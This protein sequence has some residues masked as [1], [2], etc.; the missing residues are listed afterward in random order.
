MRSI[1]YPQC[2]KSDSLYRAGYNQLIA[3]IFLLDVR[4]RYHY[5]Y[6]AANDKKVAITIDDG[7]NNPA[8]DQLLST[9]KLYNVP[10]TLFYIGERALARP[11]LVKKAS[12]LGFDVEDHTFTHAYSVQSSYG[13]LSFE[14]Q[15]TGYLLNQITG[16]KPYFYRPPYLLG[17]GIDPTINPYIKPSQDLLWALELGY[18]PVGSDIDPKDWLATSS[19]EIV[20]GLEKAIHESNNGHIILLHED[21]VTAR[22]IG[23]VVAYLRD[24]GYTI[25]PLKELLTPPTTFALAGTMKAGDTDHTTA[26][27]V[28]KL[29]WFLYK[30][31]YLD[32]YALTGVFDEQTKDA[33][34]SF[35]VD[36]KLVDS[37]DPNLQI[38][39]IA[40]PATRA[41]IQK[42][43]E[44]AAVKNAGT[45]LVYTPTVF[46]RIAGF[47][48][49]MLRGFY[50]T[51]F[52]VFFSFL[53]TMI[54]LT[55]L[56]V[57]GRSLGLVALLIWGK[58]RNVV[59]PPISTTGSEGVSILIPAYNEQENIAATVESVIRTSYPTREI[60]VIDDGSKDNTSA[61]VEA[62]IRAYPNDGVRLVRVENGGKARALN[63]GLEYAKYDTIVVLDADAVL[64]KD[65]LWHFTRHFA[66]PNVGAVAGKVRTTGSS[67]L[68][69]LFQ[70]LEYAV[71]QNIDKRA[72][73]LLGAVGVVPGPAGAW[74]RKVIMKLGGFSTDTLVEDQDLTLTILRAG[75]RVIYEPE[76][77]AYTETPHNIRNFLKQRFRWVY[78]TM[79][80]FWKHKAVY[81]ESGG[82][83][84]PLSLIVFSRTSLSLTSSCRLSIRL[85]TR[86][87]FWALPRSM[88]HPDSAVLA[89]YCFR[90]GLRN[91]G[92]V[93]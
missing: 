68:L 73:S 62:V 5:Y 83:S 41:L 54:F 6:S 44:A 64:D 84:Q 25:V 7:P 66:D 76:A 30:Q 81:L 8:T 16:N 65:A 49:D 87:S 71:G 27:G 77:V 19:S 23:K 20:A 48:G 22:S 89:L 15:S 92:S 75:Y 47:A 13:R 28:S 33:L 21:V 38:A 46:A 31:N 61:E 37:Q 26:G 2:P 86:H 10:A 12:D 59:P 34:T 55:L 80:C 45:Q 14:L 60:I 11:D 79:Q 72:F 67:T 70:T 4:T 74:R 78:G 17:I 57:L 32:P 58:I 56:L 85:Q 3:Q 35:Q 90:P 93:G 40:G 29:Q 39:G 36:N 50:I 9:L 52:P 53:H 91:V 24:N 88:E 82:Q 1:R 42:V 43:S 51:V 63:T 69:D 18:L